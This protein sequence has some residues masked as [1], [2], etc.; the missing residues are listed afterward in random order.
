MHIL[1]YSM[2]LNGEFSSTLAG[3]RYIADAFKK[4]GDEFEEIIMPK[5]GNVTDEE[6]EKFGKADLVVLAT[7]MYHFI[8]A[9]QAMSAMSKIGAYLKENYPNK[10]V[11]VFMTSNFLMD[12]LVRQYI[13]SWSDSNGLNYIKGFNMHMDDILDDDKRNAAYAWFQAV[14]LTMS[15]EAI[16]ADEPTNVVIL[17]ADD[18][19][20]T[21][22][23]VEQYKSEFE[24]RNTSVKVLKISDYNFKHCLGCQACYTNRHCFMENN[25]DFM[26][27][28]RETTENVDVFLTVGELNNGYYSAEYKSFWDRHVFMGRCPYPYD[29]EIVTLYAFHRGEQYTENDFRIIDTWAD[30][31]GSFGGDVY[32]GVFEGVNTQAVQAAI[33]AIN[34]GCTYYDN[35]YRTYITKQFADLAINIQNLEPLDYKCF[36]SRGCYEPV[37]V[38][39]NCRPIQSVEMAKKAV[40]MKSFAVRSYRN[41]ADRTYTKQL[42]R[43]HKTEDY[44]NTVQNPPYAN[45]NTTPKKKGFS[46][47]GKKG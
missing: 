28:L 11:T 47:F 41:Q 22:E 36:K 35:M 23:M 17:A 5:T 18:T 45:E 6:L 3:T 2:S 15:K 21:V 33:A 8:I 10:P 39:P 37:P 4:Q 13:E 19:P 24:A 20:K 25:D 1:V 29:T 32:L 38:N 31:M 9:S 14:K 26:K 16:S 46:F 34:A 30:A 27:L 44:I 40:E 12:P 7:S 43:I 42:R